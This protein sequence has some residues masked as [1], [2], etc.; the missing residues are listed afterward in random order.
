[1]PECEPTVEVELEGENSQHVGIMN[2]VANAVLGI[3]PLYAPVDDGLAGVEFA[4]AMHLSAWL[5][6]TVSLPINDELFYEE[7]KKRIA[8]SKPREAI[9]AKVEIQG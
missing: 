8:I 4:N 6:E 9:K 2:N 5:D 3:E 7:L 1:M